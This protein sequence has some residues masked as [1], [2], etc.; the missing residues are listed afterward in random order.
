MN[1]LY[2]YAAIFFSTIAF[3]YWYS[4][5]QYEAGVTATTAVYEKRMKEALQGSIKKS[6]KQAKTDAYILAGSIG[7]LNTLRTKY[8]NLK[9][10]ASNTTICKPD[11]IGLYNDSIRASN[12]K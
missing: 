12:Q 10:K 6:N 8:E 2:I 11:F 7:E 4:N 9:I 3:I 5:N 1:K